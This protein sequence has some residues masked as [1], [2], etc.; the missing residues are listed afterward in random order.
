MGLIKTWVDSKTGLEWH[1]EPT[2]KRMN[3]RAA[4]EFAANLKMAGGGWRLPTR[5]E[6]KGISGMNR[7]RQLHGKGWFWSSSPVNDSDDKA[8]IINFYDGIV[9]HDYVHFHG[10]VR[11]VRLLKG[12]ELDGYYEDR[13]KR[14]KK[15]KAKKKKKKGLGTIMFSPGA[16]GPKPAQLVTVKGMAIYVGISAALIGV[17]YLMKPKKD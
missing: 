1:I 12:Q 16:R 14:K 6:L 3:W 13:T 10:H 9:G 8:W 4:K 7:P 17:L 11:C 5:G 15:I 2:V